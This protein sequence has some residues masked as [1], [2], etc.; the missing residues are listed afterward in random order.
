MHRVPAKGMRGGHDAGF[1]ESDN[2]IVTGALRVGGG[3][4]AELQCALLQLGAGE[5]LVDGAHLGG[6]DA[7]FTRRIELAEHHLAPG[8]AHEAL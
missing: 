6:V 4:A 5:H 3:L 1:G 7:D 2:G 8:A